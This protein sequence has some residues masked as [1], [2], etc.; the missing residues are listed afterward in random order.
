MMQLSLG[1]ARCC[2]DMYFADCT[3][4]MTNEHRTSTPI[5]ANAYCFS[6][7]TVT[8]LPASIAG[9]K[10]EPS[11]KST[12]ILRH[13]VRHWP[14]SSLASSCIRNSLSPADSA[15]TSPQASPSAVRAGSWSSQASATSS[16][17]SGSSLVRLRHC[18]RKSLLSAFSS[19]SG[20]VLE[21]A[22][23]IGEEEE[24]EVPLVFNFGQLASGVHTR[25]F[26][27]A[28]QIL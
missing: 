3:R 13:S 7:C 19:T 1:A 8:F 11:P 14:S 6:C 21:R 23:S 4:T 26:I 2:L 24:E 16:R 5:S 9:S 17:R 12:P 22:A 10:T 18:S 25:F 27:P 28:M 20:G 15:V